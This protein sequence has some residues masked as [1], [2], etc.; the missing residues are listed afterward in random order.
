MEG[1]H[2]V[3]VT[4]QRWCAGAW[5]DTAAT[6]AAENHY[7]KTPVQLEMGKKSI[8]VTTKNIKRERVSPHISFKSLGIVELY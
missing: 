2:I 1:A 4:L 8:K 6:A 3:V 5:S 7:N